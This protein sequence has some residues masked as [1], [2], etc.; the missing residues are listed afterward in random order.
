MRT[1][2]RFGASSCSIPHASGV[3][4]LGRRPFCVR[5]RLDIMGFGPGK[6]LF[7]TETATVL[8]TLL[9][10]LATAGMI[11]TGE[12]LDGIL[13][14]KIRERKT[15]GG[16]QVTNQCQAGTESAG[17]RLPGVPSGPRH[18]FQDC[19]LKDDSTRG[20]YRRRQQ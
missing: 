5:R 17:Q 10:G 3:P 20:D 14:W 15:H 19:M 11:L 7:G 8:P 12:R 16:G 9:G 6:P 13:M 4:S 18:R 1:G 2:A